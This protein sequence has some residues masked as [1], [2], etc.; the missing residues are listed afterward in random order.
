MVHKT[1]IRASSTYGKELGLSAAPPSR[2]LSADAAHERPP[3]A[4][5]LREDHVAG[6]RVRPTDRRPLPVARRTLVVSLNFFAHVGRLI[7]WSKCSRIFW[8]VG[9]AVLEQHSRAGKQKEEFRNSHVTA[10]EPTSPKSC[11]ASR[12]GARSTTLSLCRF[13]FPDAESASLWKHLDAQPQFDAVRA[14]A[15]VS[16]RVIRVPRVDEVAWTR[17]GTAQEPLAMAEAALLVVFES[18]AHVVSKE[19]NLKTHSLG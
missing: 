12:P 17:G 6:L 3:G 15:N 13:L 8:G 5:V 16:V 9:L 14:L 7:P 2:L 18:L 11:S 19:Q 1:A 10:R 4:A